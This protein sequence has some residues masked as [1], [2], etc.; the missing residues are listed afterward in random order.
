MYK[1][2]IVDN[3]TETRTGL[4]RYFPWEDIGYTV[5]GHCG[6]GM[7]ALD[8]MTSRQVDVL[9]CDIRM[10]RLSGLEVARELRSRKHKVKIVFISGH[11]DFEYAQEALTYEVKA[12]LLKP[13]RYEELA[14]VFSEIKMEL[15]AADPVSAAT[16]DIPAR[17]HEQIVSRI[18]QYVENQYATATLEEAA[19]L[20]HM[21]A[22]YVSKYFHERAGVTFSDYLTA[23]KMR[24]AAELLGDISYKTYEISERVG[25]GHAKNFTRTFKKYYGVTPREYR[26]GH[27]ETGER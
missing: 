11:R 4:A 12:Y 2:L 20:V 9:L 16:S 15:D 13:T 19:A 1:L 17:H 26:N 25:Y 7:E 27:Q 14:R 3:E 5:V 24:K 10:P 22:H 21:H 8:F 18:K 23:V 6:D